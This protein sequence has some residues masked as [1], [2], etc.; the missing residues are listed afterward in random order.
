MQIARMIGHNLVLS[1]ICWVVP[2]ESPQKIKR[3]TTIIER[4]NINC[5]IDAWEARAFTAVSWIEKP[6]AESTANSIAFCV[7]LIGHNTPFAADQNL[8]RN[9][10]A[11]NRKI[12]N[13]SLKC[14]AL[15]F[16][17]TNEVWHL[18]W[19]YNRPYKNTSTTLSLL[20][21][22]DAQS[23]FQL[24]N[25]Q[26]ILSCTSQLI[27]WHMKICPKIITL[28]SFYLTECVA[29]LFETKSLVINVIPIAA[30]TIM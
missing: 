30:S 20:S 4:I 2:E 15:C 5:Q 8:Y 27:Q 10:T 18:R 23:I 19:V 11:S 1:F 26:E 3:Q 29:A 16:K 9:Y 6:N 21:K 12:R 14:L 28:Y 24:S 25:E 22:S 17:V 13:Q 7:L